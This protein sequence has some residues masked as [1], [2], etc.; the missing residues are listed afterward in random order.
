M[1]EGM[2]NNLLEQ[3]GFK[4][5]VLKLQIAEALKQCKQ[6]SDDVAY[7]RGVLELQETERKRITGE[8]H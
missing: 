7:I 4:P 6:V 8:L 2:I 3:W 1:F 5:E